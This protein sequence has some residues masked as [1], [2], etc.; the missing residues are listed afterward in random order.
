MQAQLSKYLL[1]TLG[2]DFCNEI[3]VYVA[4]ECNIDLK[5]LNLN[6]EQR[7]KIAKDCEPE[8]KAALQELNKYADKTI[9]EFLTNTEAAMK[10][11]SM[12]IQDVNKNKVAKL[13]QQHKDKLLQELNGTSEPAMLLHLTALVI[14]TAVTGC[15]LHATDNFVSHILGH[16]RPSLT[17]EQNVLLMQYHGEF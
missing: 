6:A 1:N 16:I 11:C 3:A 14:F 15:I 9:E 7:N 8:Y 10:S 5:S 4:I 17:E 2:K 13:I 12:I